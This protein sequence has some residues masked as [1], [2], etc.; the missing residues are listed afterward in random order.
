ML[1]H[2]NPSARWHTG[3]LYHQFP[4]FLKTDTNLSSA[5][6]T[7]QYP[8]NV[9]NRAF[10]T[11]LCISLHIKLD[12]YCSFSGPQ[13]PGDVP[14]KQ[15]HIKNTLYKTTWP[16]QP[17]LPVTGVLDLRFTLGVWLPTEH[18]E[19]TNTPCCWAAAAHSR[20]AAPACSIC[21]HGVLLWYIFNKWEKVGKVEEGKKKRVHRN[22]TALHLLYV[23]CSCLW[24]ILQTRTVELWWNAGMMMS[25]PCRLTW[26]E[27]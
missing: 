2:L 11:Y 4:A 23:F 22:T 5:A 7:K 26:D 10:D 15:E 27:R 8:L 13:S 6:V 20:V 1:T 9:I 21:L 24:H 18:T 19:H 17:R 14:L 12:M 25:W 3:V 16:L